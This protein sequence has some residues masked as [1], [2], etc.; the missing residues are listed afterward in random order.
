M[1]E[2]MM[3]W[4]EMQIWLPTLI[5]LPVCEIYINRYSNSAQKELSYTV[6][7]GCELNFCLAAKTVSRY[8]GRLRI[9]FKYQ[10]VNLGQLMLMHI[11]SLH[12]LDT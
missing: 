1:T 12:Y 7:S 5:L 6:S 8:T 3:L 4:L 11:M 10:L 2:H 9:K